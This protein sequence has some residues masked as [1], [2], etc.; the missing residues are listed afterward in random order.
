M[1]RADVAVV[2]GQEVQDSR[3]LLGVQRQLVASNGRTAGAPPNAIMLVHDTLVGK[4]VAN[5]RVNQLFD[6]ARHMQAEAM[7]RL[8]DGDIRDAA[9]KAW[10]ATKRASE[11]LILARTGQEP[12]T[13]AQTTAGI[14]TLAF[15]DPRFQ[16][17]RAYYTICVKELHSDCFYDGHCEP[18]EELA[19][20]IDQGADFVTDAERLAS[21]VKEA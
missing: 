6:D 21:E 4:M 5:D 2:V 7:A 20:T 9:E 10:C 17:L 11:A 8:A 13:P 14:R 12:N 19:A 1:R 3:Y 15:H 16:P 18:V